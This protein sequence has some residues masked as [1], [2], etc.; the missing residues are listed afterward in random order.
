MS[1]SRDRLT[2]DHISI[3]QERGAW[4]AIP[5]RD[6]CGPGALSVEAELIL[7]IALTFPRFQAP[8]KKEL[9]QLQKERAES[10]ASRYGHFG[11]NRVQAALNELQERGFYGLRRSS[12]GRRPGSKTADWA[13]VRSFGNEPWKHLAGLKALTKEEIFM[14]WRAFRDAWANRQAPVAEVIDLHEHRRK[15]A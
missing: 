2:S 1:L 6:R 14:H 10:S 8:G 7:G 13:Y 12:T 3:P 15:T 5:D 11:M 4:V 9:W